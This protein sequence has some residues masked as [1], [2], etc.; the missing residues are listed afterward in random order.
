M[1]GADRRTVNATWVSPALPSATSTSATEMVGTLGVQL[2]TLTLSR[3]HPV[4]PEHPSVPKFQRSWT[5]SPAFA[6]FP[7]FTWVRPQDPPFT[8]PPFVP[9]Q[10][11]WPASG[12]VLP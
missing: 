3:Y 2:N 12:F 9:V 11:G 8:V 6:K 4:L 7:R 1:V 5:V 10:A